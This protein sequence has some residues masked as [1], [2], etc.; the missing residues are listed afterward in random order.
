MSFN[1]H[2]HQIA[3]TGLKCRLVEN[4]AILQMVEDGKSYNEIVFILKDRIKELERD[5]KITQGLVPKI[6]GVNN[7]KI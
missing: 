7:E 3:I 4:M 2:K 6:K 1:P 5:I